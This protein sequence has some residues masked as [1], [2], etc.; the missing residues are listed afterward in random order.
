MRAFLLAA[1]LGTR[2]R[3][4]TESIPKALVLVNDVPMIEYPL[5]YLK[6]IGVQE[7]CINVHYQSGKLIKYLQSERGNDG[8][9]IIIQDETE[10]LLDSGGGL[11]KIAD[12][13]FAENENALYMNADVL[14]TP[15]FSTILQEHLKGVD[16]QGYEITMPLVKSKLVGNK[17]NGVEVIQDL[18]SR[19]VPKA[20]ADA[21]EHFHW[22]SMMLINQKI[23]RFLGWHGEV[24]SIKDAVWK[25]LIQSKAIHALI[26]DSGFCDMG[27]VE[28]VKEA[29]R[30]LQNNEFPIYSSFL[31]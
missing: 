12:W 14:F 31:V 27:D 3:P 5:A 22:P 10:K 26:C 20:Q 16:S 8:L 1:G 19:F 17:F 30:R 24:F 28:N 7:V 23:R 6:S 13:L 9:R 11:A 25:P 18:V 21:R 29:E 4:L 2:M 15:D